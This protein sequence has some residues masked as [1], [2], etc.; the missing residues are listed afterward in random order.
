VQPIRY[1]ETKT[2]EEL[3]A[4]DQDEKAIHR[5]RNAIVLRVIDK[6]DLLIGEM[7]TAAKWYRLTKDGKPVEADPEA[8][9]FKQ[10]LARAGQWKFPILRGVIG[11]PTLDSRGGIVE[12]P[13][14]DKSTG[15]FLDFKTGDFMP[16]PPKPSKDD[17]LAALAKLNQPLRG[18]PFDGENETTK[19]S[20]SRSV[21]LSAILCA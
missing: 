12:K 10:V 21:A 7:S 1:G 4:E 19:V 18:F 13:G 20:P 14:Y 17:A 5:D 9:Y 15:L 6:P 3:D 8:K 16:I 2:E 11:A